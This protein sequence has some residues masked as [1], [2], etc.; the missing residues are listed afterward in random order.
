MAPPAPPLRLLSL[1]NP[2]EE[3]PHRPKELTAKSADGDYQANWPGERRLS[4]LCTV[5]MRREPCKPGGNPPVR[6]PQGLDTDI[7]AGGWWGGEDSN[8]RPS[9]YN[10]AKFPIFL[11]VLASEKPAASGLFPLD[12]VAKQSG[13]VRV[14]RRTDQLHGPS[15]PG[16]AHCRG[17]GQW[18]RRAPG[19]ASRPWRPR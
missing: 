14:D 6:A 10:A 12:F 15:P 3:C 8:S 17:L 11:S 2:P 13:T 9:S 18:E 16:Q 7:A 5:H 19:V 4:R 1:T